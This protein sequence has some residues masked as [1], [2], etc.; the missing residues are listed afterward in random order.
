MQ[1]LARSY[2]HIG[3]LQSPVL[4]Q[5]SRG[6]Y[7]PHFA[8]A[9]NNR[10]FVQ[11]INV[12]DHWICVYNVFGASSNEV[13]V[14]DSMYGAMTDIILVQLTSLLRSDDTDSYSSDKIVIC[15]RT[16]CQQ[17]PGNRACGYYACAAAISLCAGIDPTGNIYNETSLKTQI[18]QKY[19][20]TML[21]Q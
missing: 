19:T 2:P 6:M 18:W 5:C 1:T 20:P 4:G 10:R 17:S 9:T 8:P 21:N 3:G 11:V 15:V 12:G 14:Y 7:L 16:F 13:H